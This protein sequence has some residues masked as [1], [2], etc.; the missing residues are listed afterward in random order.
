MRLFDSL[1]HVTADGR[2]GAGVHDY[3]ASCGRLLSELDRVG[4]HRACLVAIAGIADNRTTMDVA[5]RYADRFIPVG[6]IDPANEVDPVTGVERLAAA[7]FAGLKLHPRLHGYDPLDERCRAAIDAAG[8][9]GLTV[10][11]DTLFRQRTRSTAHPIDVVDELLVT[12]P[13]CRFVLL[14]ATGATALEL[15]ELGRM[16]GHALID[17][18][19]TLMRYAGSSV[20]DDIGF[21]CEQL[22]QRVCIGSDFPE[23]TPIEALTRF[24][25]LTLGLHEDKRENVAWRN[26]NRWFPLDPEAG[27]VPDDGR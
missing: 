8:Q 16:H 3:D 17:L 1:T 25:R 13:G 24:E 7:G 22:D 18:S 21:L 11:L 6:S 4:P 2:W 9:S 14:H 10:F 26:L 19:F 27:A 15:F 20:D 23:Y 12:N 5:S